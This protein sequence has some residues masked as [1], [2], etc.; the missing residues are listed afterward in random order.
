MLCLVV[1]LGEGLEICGG[2]GA[3]G[4]VRVGKSS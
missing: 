1:V 2:V 4:E 3:G